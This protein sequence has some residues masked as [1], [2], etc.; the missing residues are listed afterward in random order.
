MAKSLLTEFFNL[1]PNGNCED[2]LTEDDKRM[3]RDGNII[4]TGKIQEADTKNANGRIY[5][6]RILEREIDKYQQLIEEKRALGTLDHGV[7]EVLE[8]R[9][10]SHI[11]TEVWWDGNTVMGKLRVLK[12]P[13]GQ[14]LETLIK[15]GV[16]LGISSRALG[17]VTENRNGTVVNEDLGLISF[18]I[19]SFPSTNRAFLQQVSSTGL[20]ES[21]QNKISSLVNEILK[22][23]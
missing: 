4:L 19:V 17:S 3:V 18:D 5:P 16:M 9:D 13:V 8:L 12:T 1:C 14:I 7:S 15:E 23:R 2:L 20:N 22:R 6:R 21:K 10:A 11:M